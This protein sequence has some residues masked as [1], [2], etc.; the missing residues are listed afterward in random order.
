MGTH[1]EHYP[2]QGQIIYYPTLNKARPRISR[3]RA[4]GQVGPANFYS[5]RG[6]TGKLQTL[7]PTGF[8]PYGL[9][10]RPLAVAHPHSATEETLVDQYT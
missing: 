10:A 6:V 5:N 8:S 3:E 1:K 7:T 4:A 2:H 9:G